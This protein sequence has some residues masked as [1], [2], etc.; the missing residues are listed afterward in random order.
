M[1]C[2]FIGDDFG[3]KAVSYDIKQQKCEIVKGFELSSN[4]RVMDPGVVLTKDD[5]YWYW[6]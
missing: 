4:D 5:K 1:K 6:K 3:A 2:I